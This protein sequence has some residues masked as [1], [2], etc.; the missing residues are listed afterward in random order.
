ARAEFAKLLR[1]ARDLKRDSQTPPSSGIM[2]A[3]VQN[4]MVADPDVLAG[5]SYRL[6]KKIGEGASGEVYE[7]E[8]IE[9]GRRYAVKVLSPAHAAAHDAV[10]RFRREARAIASLS[11]PNL[12]ALHD[13][14]KSLDGRVFLVMELL[15]GET[16]DK[17]AERGIDWRRA[18]DLAIK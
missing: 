4:A 17:H 13:F 12:V 16:L 5:T 1:Q 10:E 7:A 6:L 2:Q 3:A 18:I 8:H 15:S 14:G 11:H 9:L